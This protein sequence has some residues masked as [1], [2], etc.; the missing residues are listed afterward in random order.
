MTK[1]NSIDILKFIASFFVVMIHIS[2]F[3]DVNPYLN[4]FIANG[5]SRLAVPIFFLASAFFFYKKNLN[6]DVSAQ[7]I[8]LLKY[9]K[10][11]LILY[12]GWFIIMLPKTIYERFF[13]EKSL[14]VNVFQFVK[15]FF[16]TST[17]SGSWFLVSCLFSVCVLFF[18]YN[19]FKEKSADKIII[20]SSISCYLLCVLT[21]AYGNIFVNA[22]LGNFYDSFVFYFTKPYTSI[23]VGVPYFALGR[24][25][26]KNDPH[27][28]LIGKILGSISL[29]LFF[30][31]I[32]LT[33]NL[34]L[35]MSSDCFLMLLP[36]AYFIF[37]L[38]KDIKVELKFNP[39]ILRNASTIIFF[40]HFI[41]I[42]V[43]EVF[44]KI[45]NIAVISTYRLIIVSVLCLLTVS[46]FLTL[47]KKKIFSWLKYLY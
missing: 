45:F 12:F 6:L 8:S 22:G 24:Y 11:M 10:R 44:E 29:V 40:S 7:K 17:F 1:Y 13:N 47:S 37:V 42:F 32:L 27:L 18:V 5:L 25:I 19:K 26:A 4:L 21:S 38:I 36:C 3:N 23:L 39:V 41:W 43:I 35:R 28:T 14:S 46:I 16:L 20:V 33:Y 15:S 2:L 31:E 9:T 34:D 30:I